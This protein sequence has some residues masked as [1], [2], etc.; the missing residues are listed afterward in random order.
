[1][2]QQSE[3]LTPGTWAGWSTISPNNSPGFTIWLTG[4][5]GTGKT[6]L[7]SF[8]KKV[9]VTRGFNVEIIDAQTLSHW[10]DL[11]L[12]LKEELSEDTSYTLGYDAFVTYVCALLTRNSIICIT[13]FVSPFIAA[14]NFAREQI[15]KFIEVY[16]HCSDEQSEKR[17]GH[18][19]HF[20]VHTPDL[21]Q[22]PE[23][24]EL[25][26]DTS[27]EYPEQSTMHLISYL[28]QHSYIAPL[29]EDVEADEEI[30]IIK[31]RLQAL[32]YLD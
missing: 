24:P 7:A 9:L 27:D 31:T 10:M 13:S 29:W 20:S 3:N 28:E 21:Y 4:L 2:F 30:T 15:P 19:E 17:L 11:E 26:I 25:S 5:P 22:P 6:T 14:R 23:R 1:M 12:Q 32:G 16:L 8:L 18:I